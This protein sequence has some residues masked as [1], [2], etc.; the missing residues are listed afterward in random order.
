[1]ETAECWEIALQSRTQPSILALT[2]QKLKPMRTE[3]T[4]TNM[5]ALGAYE[6]A[7]TK[8]S[9]VVI[10][11]SGSEVEIAMQAKEILDAQGLGARVVSV[12]SMELFEQQSDDYK[13][14]LMGKE[15]VRMAIEAGVRQSWDRFIGSD[16]LFIGMTGF[17]ASAPA[18]VLYEKFGITAKHAVAAVK[19][20]LGAR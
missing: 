8:K 16:G 5:C 6:V 7:A 2:R 11:A 4:S 12:P 1:M 15:K 20:R 19:T 17:G 13:R 18:E 10:F 3:F 14:K 9:A